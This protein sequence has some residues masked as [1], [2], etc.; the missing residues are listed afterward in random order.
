[1]VGELSVE[2]QAIDHP[3]SVKSTTEGGRM[4]TDEHGLFQLRSAWLG[5]D[6][7][8]VAGRSQTKAG[9]PRRSQTKAG[10]LRLCGLSAFAL[11]SGRLARVRNPK[12]R[13]NID[14]SRCHGSGGGKGVVIGCSAPKNGRTRQI[15]T[16]LH[17]LANR[18]KC[19]PER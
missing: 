10:C 6:K 16:T 12:T 4:D 17:Y 2:S 14:L 19:L 1:M 18:S 13:E 9:L 5:R 8:G 7:C 3:S 11:N 15:C